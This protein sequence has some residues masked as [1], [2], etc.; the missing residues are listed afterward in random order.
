MQGLWFYQFLDFMKTNW[1][2]T[3]LMFLY[4][5]SSH[6]FFTRTLHSL[7]LNFG[8]P[9]KL[10]FLVKDST[11]IGS[12][13][14]IMS[15]SQPCRWSLLGFLIRCFFFSNLIWL[16]FLA[17]AV[18]PDVVILDQVYEINHLVAFPKFGNNP[19]WSKNTYSNW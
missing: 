8:S 14:Y 17:S 9:F 13:H 2:I 5:R 19:N 11:M 12:S 3:F 18:Q 15:Y 6:T 7:W 4:C 1:A 16:E 10:V